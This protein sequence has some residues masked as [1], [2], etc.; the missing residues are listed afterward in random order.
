M[1]CTVSKLFHTE[2][3]VIFVKFKKLGYLSQYKQILQVKTFCQFFN[4]MH[5]KIIS[6]KN[7]S[8]EL[9]FLSCN[10]HRQVCDYP[11]KAWKPESW[12]TSK[13]DA[14]HNKWK[15]WKVEY[16]MLLA[17]LVNAHKIGQK[18]RSFQKNPCYCYTA[19]L[20]IQIGY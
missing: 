12:F 13:S 17:F 19:N 8:I 2:E 15:Q 1:K 11:L 10:W 14:I 20:I 9:L 4:F 6:F 5:C 18:F 16:F 3:I 7:W